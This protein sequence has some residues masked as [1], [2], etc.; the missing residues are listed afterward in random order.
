MTPAEAIETLI[1]MRD[2][3]DPRFMSWTRERQKSEALRMAIDL[4]E[5]ESENNEKSIVCK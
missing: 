4:L 3:L 1:A 5:K 2:N